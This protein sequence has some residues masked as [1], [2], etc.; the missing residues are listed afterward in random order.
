MDFSVVPMRFGVRRGLQ[1]IGNDCGLQ[2]DEFSVHFEPFDS[3]FMDFNDFDDFAVVSDGLTLFP[4]GP[5]TLR[6]CPEGPGTLRKW[7]EMA[8]N[9]LRIRPIE[10]HSHSPSFSNPPKNS[11][12]SHQYGGELIFIFLNVRLF[13]TLGLFGVDR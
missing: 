4:E 3:I 13:L 5:R 8:R 1:S 7:I 10:A 11:Q 2:M 9:E 6:N 12:G